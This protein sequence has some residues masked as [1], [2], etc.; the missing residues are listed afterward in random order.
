MIFNVKNTRGK[1]VKVHDVRGT[2]VK[3][4]YYYNTKTRLTKMYLM[5]QGLL[6]D[7]PRV[8]MTRPKGKQR[9]DFHVEI[10]K[11]SLIL[12]GST[13]EVNGKVY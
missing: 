2:E 6:K 4:V 9:S 12:K 7:K 11:V 10:V 5:G 8:L 13:I 1:T 3:G